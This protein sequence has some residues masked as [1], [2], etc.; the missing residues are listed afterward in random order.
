MSIDKSIPDISQLYNR[1]HS[2]FSG[3]YCIMT[4][5]GLPTATQK[6]G[7]LFVTTEP[8]PIT[9]LFPIVTPGKTTQLDPTHTLSPSTTP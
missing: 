5:A 2:P 8:A 9:E 1:T 3:L 4:L 7:T 6:A